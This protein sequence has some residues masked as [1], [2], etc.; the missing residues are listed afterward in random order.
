MKAWHL[1][2]GWQLTEIGKVLRRSVY[3]TAPFRRR[4]R[5]HEPR[6]LNASIGHLR[7]ALVYLL[8]LPVMWFLIDAT[9]GATYG[10]LLGM[11]LRN[12]SSPPGGLGG[13]LP[14]SR[15]R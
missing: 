3:K 6:A 8:A 4:Y 11:Q 14:R 15:P 2:R 5:S 13:V 12:N 1:A 9:S 7:I 10:V